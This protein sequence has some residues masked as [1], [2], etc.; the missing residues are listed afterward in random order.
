MDATSRYAPPQDD[1]VTDNGVTDEAESLPA[2]FAL[3]PSAAQIP[4]S[5]SLISRR[6]GSRPC[7]SSVP[8]SPAPPPPPR[9]QPGRPRPGQLRS[10][11]TGVL[12]EIPPPRRSARIAAR[13]AVAEPRTSAGAAEEGEPR[14]RTRAGRAARTRTEG[15]A[16]KSG[17]PQRA[18]RSSTTTRVAAA[19]PQG[20][21][22]ERSSRAKMTGRTAC[23]FEPRA[24]CR[25]GQD[26]IR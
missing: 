24:K 26:R 4:V 9:R 19:T 14:L 22:Q 21:G 11:G 7:R 12:S 23:G 25:H 16:A 6:V 3:W 13:Q 10:T 18:G 8:S 20:V 2:R 1:G 17:R 15:S 5:H